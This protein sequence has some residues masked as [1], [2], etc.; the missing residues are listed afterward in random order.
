MDIVSAQAE[1]TKQ[2]KNNVLQHL[3]INVRPQ[4]LRNSVLCDGV[5]I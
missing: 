5:A 4:E 1:F 3:T 2:T